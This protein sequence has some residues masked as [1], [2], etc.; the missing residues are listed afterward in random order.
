MLSQ[1][2]KEDKVDILRSKTFWGSIFL[3][4]AGILN[5]DVINATNIMEAVGIVLTAIGIRGAALRSGTQ[6]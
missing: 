3:A 2:I 6:L 1:D 5:A 4:I